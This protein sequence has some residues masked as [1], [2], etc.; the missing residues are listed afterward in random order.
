MSWIRRSL[1]AN[2]RLK[3]L[4]RGYGAF[5]SFVSPL[6]LEGLKVS[7]A[8]LRTVTMWGLGGWAIKNKENPWSVPGVP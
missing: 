8:V 5:E 4:P 3:V 1:A 6:A 7:G 2:E